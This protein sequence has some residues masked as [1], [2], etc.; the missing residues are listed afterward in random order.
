MIET[1]IEL[2]TLEN[3]KICIVLDEII[4]NNI[5]YVYLVNSQEKN[6]FTIRKVINN[7]LV[8]LNDEKEFEQTTKLFLNKNI[9]RNNNN[10]NK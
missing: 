4:L 2:I 1:D 8:G 3:N 9:E 5:K 10:N 6:D 7:E